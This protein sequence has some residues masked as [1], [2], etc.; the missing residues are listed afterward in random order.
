MTRNRSFETH[1]GWGAAVVLAAAVA[2]A[3]AWV[4]FL[5]GFAA[6][7]LVEAIQALVPRLG[8]Y[9]PKDM[10]YTGVG[11]LAGAVWALLLG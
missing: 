8:S 11:A 5:I 7:V 9:D 6:G 10:I 1:S 4:A 2:G 3:P